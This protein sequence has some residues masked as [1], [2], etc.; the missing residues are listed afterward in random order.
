MKAQVRELLKKIQSTADFGSVS[1]DSINDTN[2]LGDNALHCVCI[3]GDIEAVK[4]LVENGID[5][6]QRG[7][8]GFTPLRVAAEFGHAAI[9]EYLLAEGADPSALDAPEV[10]DREANDR[11]LASLCEQIRR[12]EDQFSSGNFIAPDKES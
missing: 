9:V 3:W 7:E 6:H 10:F 11:H 2:A 12:L 5:L 4:L 1:F 8:F